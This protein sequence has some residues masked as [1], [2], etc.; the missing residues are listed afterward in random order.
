MATTTN[1]AGTPADTTH[2]NLGADRAFILLR[3][4][5][6]IA[7]IAFGLDKFFDILTE[8]EQYLAPWINDIVPG[9]A[10]QAM[11]TVGVIEIIAGIAVAVAPRYGS[12]LV[13]GWLAGIVVNLVSMGEYYDVALRD[14][15]LLVGAIA[16][17]VLA[18]DRGKA[19]A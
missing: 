2:P 18:W 11:L 9:N 12:L 15:G 10:H 19:T 14:F 6:T 3:T 13:A 5:F 7:P 16:L 1:P 8:W 4:V 17:A